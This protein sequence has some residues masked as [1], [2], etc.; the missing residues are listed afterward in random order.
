MGINDGNPIDGETLRKTSWTPGFKRAGLK[1]RSMYHTRH[2]FT[3]LM[4]SAGENL[5]WV[6][7]MMGHASLK[8]IQECYYRFIPNLP[9]TDGSAFAKKFQRKSAQ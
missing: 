8:M 6:K 7:Q 5:G 1:Y 9:H 4:L 2:T 3:T